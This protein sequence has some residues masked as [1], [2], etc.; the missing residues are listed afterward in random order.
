MSPDKDLTRKGR[1]DIRGTSIRLN[2]I[3]GVRIVYDKRQVGFRWLP[4]FILNFLG[5]PFT[6]HRV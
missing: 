5:H 4:S 1:S 6:F 2:N 3:S